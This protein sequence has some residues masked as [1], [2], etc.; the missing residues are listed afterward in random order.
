MIERAP[1]SDRNYQKKITAYL[2]GALSTEERSEFEAFVSTHPEFKD[3][4]KLKEDEIIRLRSFIPQVTMSPSALETMNHEIRQSIFQLL[5]R[6]PKNLWENMKDR[7]EE[8][9]SNR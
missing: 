1:T 3:Q 7:Y 8:W 9:A 4:I 6:K 2:D 5:K